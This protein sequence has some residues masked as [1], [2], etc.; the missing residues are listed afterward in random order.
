MLNHEFDCIGRDRLRFYRVGFQYVSRQSLGYA[1]IVCSGFLIYINF[2]IY[3]CG[4]KNLDVGLK[5]D[6]QFKVADMQ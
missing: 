1:E 4:I 6:M 3:T 5:I 2:N